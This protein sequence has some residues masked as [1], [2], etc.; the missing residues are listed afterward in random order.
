MLL[1]SPHY[2]WYVAWLIPFLCLMPNLPVMAYTCTFFYLCYTALAVGTG[3]KQFHLN[4]ILYSTVLIAVII[5]ITLRH[6]PWTRAW[7]LPP[8]TQQATLATNQPSR[9]R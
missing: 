9:S 7:F 1:F 3:P 5:E 4:E 8:L 2:P 6:L